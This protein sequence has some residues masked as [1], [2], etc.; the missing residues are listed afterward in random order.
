MI[1]KWRKDTL[2]EVQIDLLKDPAVVED[3]LEQFLGDLDMKE[4]RL[5]PPTLPAPPKP[6]A[7]QSTRP[8]APPPTYP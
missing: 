5:I 6:T 3:R 1:V 2:T 7:I 4:A 8:Q